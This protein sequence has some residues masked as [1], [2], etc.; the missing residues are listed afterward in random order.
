MECDVI[1]IYGIVCAK[2]ADTL[3]HS[4]GPRQNK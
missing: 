3:S 4:S 2:Q 1:V